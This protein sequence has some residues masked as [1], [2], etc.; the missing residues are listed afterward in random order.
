M[1]RVALNPIVCISGSSR[2]DNNTARA[3]AVVADELARLGAAIDVLDARSL[4]LGFPG[5]PV[6]PDA[7]RL[8]R[9]VAAASA[10][11]LA[12]PEYHGTF[13]A[14]TKLIIENLGYPSA[15]EGK[16]VALLGVASG[17]IGAIKSLEQ[18]RGVCAH[19]GAI[20]LPG[21]VSVAGV[22]RAFD[23][24]GHITDAA[25][26]AAL[27]GLAGAVVEFIKDYVCPKHTL[28]A[29]V[30]QDGAPWAATL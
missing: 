5:Q 23:A 30:R 12:T 1:E 15:L 16:P 14:M 27:R 17:R 18:L 11:V 10:V 19:T 6:T 2:P 4:T 8:A 25:A 29:L 24:D 3:L 22:S 7:E 26:E 13:S 28:E 21:A 9:T 20:V